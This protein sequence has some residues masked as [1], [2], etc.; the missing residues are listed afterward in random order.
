M[1]EQESFQ[2][3]TI[4]DSVPQAHRD[5]ITCLAIDQKDPQRY[6]IASGG[7]D[8]AV[9]VWLLDTKSKDA[10]NPLSQVWFATEHVQPLTRFSF[11][12]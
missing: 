6:L 1:D 4:L 3:V 8:H 9:G 11:E 10:I 7:N 2:P 5:W 12:V